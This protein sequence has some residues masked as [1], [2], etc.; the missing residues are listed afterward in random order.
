MGPILGLLRR[1]TLSLFHCVHSFARRFDHRKVPL[2]TNAQAEL[3]AFAGVVILIEADWDQTLA[4]KRS[5]SVSNCGVAQAFFGH[6]GGGLGW[7]DS[8]SEKLAVRG[9]SRPVVTRLK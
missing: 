1:E 4:S 5:R 8:E 9:V 7:A 3:E 6:F 2:W